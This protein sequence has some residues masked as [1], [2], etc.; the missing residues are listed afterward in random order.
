MYARATIFV[1]VGVQRDLWPGGAWP[2]V[3]HDEAAG[4]QRLLALADATAVRQASIV[5]CHGA[6]D[7]GVEGAPRHCWTGEP[8]S[9]R[10][11]ECHG[12]LA[13]VLMTPADADAG[14][15]G[16]RTLALASGCADALDARGRWS[17][18]FDRLVGS[19]R[20]AVVFGAGVELGIDLVVRG[21]LTRRVRTHVVLDAAGA[22]DA[23]A[24]Q[25]VIAAWKRAGV[26]GTTVA[27]VERQL[28][29]A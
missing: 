27:M 15:G 20:D 11:E 8:G 29:A 18:V 7:G 12:R 23:V 16:G 13:R 3:T 26:D 6:T 4:V 19:V 21:L 17:V 5:C 1:D 24:A 10:P 22:V 25:R 14:R 9:E 2:L 28:G